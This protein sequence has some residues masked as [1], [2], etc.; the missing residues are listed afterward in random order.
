MNIL[1]TGATGFIGS[2]FLLYLKKNNC[3][4]TFVLLTSERIDGYKCVLH[5]DYEFSVNDFYEAGIEKID[6]VILLGAYVEKSRNEPEQTRKH[7]SSINNVDYLLHHLPNIPKKVIYCSSIAVYGFDST[8]SYRP[9]TNILYDEETPTNPIRTYALS[10]LLGERLV[11]EWGRENGCDV[12]ILRIG[13]VY[14]PGRRF[15][16]FLGTA[17]NCVIDHK[18]MSMFA[19]P[20][21]MWNFV[22]AEDVAGW[23]LNSVH[24]RDNCGVIN[25]TSSVNYTSIEVC[26]AVKQVWNSFRYDIITDIQY[27]GQDK[28]FDSRKR[29]KCLG[30]ETVSLIEGLKIIKDFNNT[31]IQ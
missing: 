1:L 23:I 27:K 17:V 26:E 10:K 3:K 22:Y 13:S 31:N 15:Y 25:L 7:L 14:G 19:P 12:Q 8:I 6:A 24:I 29:E 20:N 4:D 11:E 28:A 16:N 18:N 5:K 30:T 9:E 21:Q 2:N